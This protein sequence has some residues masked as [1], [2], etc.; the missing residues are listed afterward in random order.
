MR[1]L[2]ADDD[3][4]ARTLL[5]DLLEGFGH[6][7]I[8]AADGQAAWRRL[9]EDPEI[10]LL[11]TD[12]VM[13]E[14]DGPELCRRVR[15]AE[16]Q[17]YL[18]VILVTSLAEES[19]LIEG[20]EAGADC[21]VNKP[22]VSGVLWAQVKTCERIL[23]LEEKLSRK[24]ED[25]EEANQ[26]I[27][28]DLEAAAAIQKSHLPEKPPSHPRVEF[29]WVYDA[30]DTL[31]GDMFNVFRLDEEHVGVY[32]L[33]VSGHGTSA[34][35]LSVAI[36]R[37]LVPFPQQGGILK[38]DLPE[39]PFYTLPS[40]SEVASEL[41]RRFQTSESGLF[42]TFLYGILDLRTG[43]FRF[44][45]AGHPGPVHVLADGLTHDVGEA[46]ATGPPIGI[47]EDA[48]YGEEEIV[49]APGSKLVIYTDGV[50]ETQNG[51]GEHYGRSRIVGLLCE[52]GGGRNLED[53]VTQLRKSLRDFSEGTPQR[54]DI[55][56]VG[57]GVI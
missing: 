48:E 6:E 20:L 11:I 3:R 21:F 51:S 55:T 34:A 29:A 22:V 56:I 53:S 8:M 25:L 12:W 4:L 44:V 37:A 7:I 46:A 19:H 32:I 39:A 13:P 30:C 33:D 27:R 43:I 17:R 57:L 45:S 35:L 15:G 38:R 28:R 9:E 36:S 49:V 16:R 42:A 14:M 26:H 1:V 40:P 10:S 5:G 50:H 41:N 24:V 2:V 18:P 54:D 52:D 47:L 23:A 31:G